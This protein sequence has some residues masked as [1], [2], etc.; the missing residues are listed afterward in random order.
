MPKLVYFPLQGRVQAARYL[1][2]YK[3]VEFEDVRIQFPDWPAVKEAGTYGA[4]NSLPVYVDD[5]G[6]T[7]NQGKAILMFLAAQHGLMPQDAG[8]LYEM[9]WFYETK[10]D[11]EPKDDERGAIFTENHAQESIDKFVVKAKAMMDKFEAR[12]SDGRVHVTG[13]NLSAADFTLLADFTQLI[14]NPNLRNP[15][16]HEQLSAYAQTLSNVQR[17]LGGIKPLCQ[18]Q[19]DALQ[20][21]WI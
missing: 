1:L 8:E 4:G 18:A 15:S 6:K 19:V 11:H 17:V 2:A 10:T 16:V 7:H 13:A 9:M 14:D 5:E 3:G 21:G 12:W 20:P